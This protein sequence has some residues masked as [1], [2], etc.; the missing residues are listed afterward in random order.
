MKRRQMRHH[1]NEQLLRYVD[2]ELPSRA[3]GKVRRHLEAC[4]EC[5]A[6]REQLESTAAEC[7]SYRK[8]ILQRYLPSPPAPWFDI[9]QGF[10]EIDASME[11]G[12]F[13]R[14][15]EILEWPLHNARKL[16]AAAATL[17]VV[18]GLW[19]RFRVTP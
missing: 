2:G 4:W 19:Y 15:R 16:A 14:L 10:A 18:W 3:A 17:L 12:F 5:R 7:V 1:E 6:E 11:P 8:D 13:D 9:Y